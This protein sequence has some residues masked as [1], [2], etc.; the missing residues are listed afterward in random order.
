MNK[1]RFLFFDEIH[2]SL[3]VLIGSNQSLG[4][5]GSLLPVLWLSMARPYRLLRLLVLS[6]PAQ[7]LLGLLQSV[8]RVL[9]GH[10]ELLDGLGL[11]ADLFLI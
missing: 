2:G 3:L 10:L 1:T 5:L 11:L 9:Q 6:I 7:L 4:V 8:L